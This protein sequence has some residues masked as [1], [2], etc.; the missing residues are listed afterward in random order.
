MDRKAAMAL[1][2]RSIAKRE[3]VTINKARNAA[4][5]LA[6]SIQYPNTPEKHTLSNVPFVR[7]ITFEKD[8]CL[9]FCGQKQYK[10]GPPSIKDSERMARFLSVG[11]GL[12]L[13]KPDIALIGVM[14][15]AHSPNGYLHERLSS[16]YKAPAIFLRKGESHRNRVK[17]ASVWGFHK[18]N[19]VS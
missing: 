19:F 9:G 6:T 17:R 16:H 14:Y 3:G 11:G 15:W 7:Y 4:S 5:W 13:F 12:G 1:A 8:G 10:S 18:G 2:A